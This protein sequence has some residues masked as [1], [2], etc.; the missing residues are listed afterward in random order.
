[1]LL[2]KEADRALFA[3]NP[4]SLCLS[5]TLHFSVT[6]ITFYKSRFLRNTSI[7]FSFRYLFNTVLLY[8]FIQLSRANFF[9]DNDCCNNEI[10]TCQ[11]IWKWIEKKFKMIQ[12][13]MGKI[14]ETLI[15]FPVF[16]TYLISTF[17]STKR[18]QVCVYCDPRV[19]KLW[20]TKAWEL[21]N[22]I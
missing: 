5:H 14:S 21:H 22:Y 19:W 13:N 11:W 4:F 7:Y 17:L 12:W 20:K 10:K 6:T 16:K 3:F 1:M 2:N 18:S 8:H 9:R 15:L